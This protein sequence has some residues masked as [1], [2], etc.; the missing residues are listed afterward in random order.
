MQSPVK[1]L[2][3]YLHIAQ[4]LHFRGET[5][6]KRKIL[7]EE[8]EYYTIEREGKKRAKK[9]HTDRQVAK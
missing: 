1:R 9:V 4:K 5:E 8:E 3:S 2:C 7:K 6:N